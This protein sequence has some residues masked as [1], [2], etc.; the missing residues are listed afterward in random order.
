MCVCVRVLILDALLEFVVFR[1]II[2]L[3]IITIEAVEWPVAR[4]HL[5]FTIHLEFYDSFE[6]LDKRENV[7]MRFFQ[8]SAS[9]CS[10]PPP[11]NI[12]VNLAVKGSMSLSF[13]NSATFFF[14][15]HLVFKTW[16]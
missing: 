6:S 12:I 4:S 9:S 8:P 5:L 3:Q 15:C 2:D 16:Q 11:C 7:R 1:G 10:P 13:E 14:H